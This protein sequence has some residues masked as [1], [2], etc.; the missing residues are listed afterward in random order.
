MTAPTPISSLVHSSTLVTAGV[1]LLIRYRKIIIINN[2]NFYLTLISRLTI[3]IAGLIANFEYDLKKIIAFSTLRQLGFILIILRLGYRE[4]AFFHLVVH[5][6]FKSNIFICAG[7]FI[8]RIIGNQDIRKY[9]GLVKIFPL[10][11]IIII[12]CLLNLAG[13]PFRSGFYSKDIFLEYFFAEKYNLIIIMIVYIS[14]FLTI[15][16]RIRLIK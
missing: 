8:H 16:Y 11:R 5:A 14:T 1:Y 3:L 12:I 2:I 6:L 7:D 4:L 15:C 13:F 9:G 10:K